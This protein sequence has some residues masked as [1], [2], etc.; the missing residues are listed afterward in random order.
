MIAKHL[1]DGWYWGFPQ[2]EGEPNYEDR[3]LDWL[4]EHWHWDTVKDGLEG[5]VNYQ[6]AF[7]IDDRVEESVVLVQEQASP[8]RPIPIRVLD[9][10]QKVKETIE[11]QSKP[12]PVTGGFKFLAKLR[13]W[14]R[15][16]PS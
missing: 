2:K 12:D 16:L 6:L 15:N 14:W 11:L 10:L 13:T 9:D 1:G 4:N 7:E 3:L 8:I 5:C